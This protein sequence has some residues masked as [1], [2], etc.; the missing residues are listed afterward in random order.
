MSNQDLFPI[1]TKFQD[2]FF[3]ELNELEGS[4]VTCLDHFNELREVNLELMNKISKLEAENQQLKIKVSDLEK[5]ISDLREVNISIVNG[6]E[7]SESSVE[8]KNLIKRTI[9]RIDNYINS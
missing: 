5:D 4:L 8:V 3:Q 7:R 6:E 9:D 1:D 2:A